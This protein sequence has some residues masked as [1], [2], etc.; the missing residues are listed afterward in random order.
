MLATELGVAIKEG[1]CCENSVDIWYLSGGIL[2][3][4]FLRIKEGVGGQEGARVSVAPWLSS[5]DEQS[6]AAQGSSLF[7]Q[8]AGRK[9]ACHVAQATTDKIIKIIFIQCHKTTT[10]SEMELPGSKPQ[11]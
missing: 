6:F 2:K 9:R 5:V 11:T 10:D 1:G 7:Q 3:K 4:G 8:R